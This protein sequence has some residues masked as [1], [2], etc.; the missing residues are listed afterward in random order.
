MLFFC[1]VYS[2]TN[3]DAADSLCAPSTPYLASSPRSLMPN[4]S[5]HSAQSLR[6]G[7]AMQIGTLSVHF[8]CI[9]SLSFWPAEFLMRKAG[10]ESLVQRYRQ[11]I[12]GRSKTN[13]LPLPPDLHSGP[14]RQLQ[15]IHYRPESNK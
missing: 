11:L 3:V 13:T 15:W 9:Q 14:V 4:V 8:V 6:S 7:S 2:V 5:T 10:S 1:S 12:G